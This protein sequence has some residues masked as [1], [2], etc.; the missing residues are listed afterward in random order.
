M[1]KQELDILK[2]EYVKWYNQKTKEFED[3]ITGNIK[4][5]KSKKKTSL[6]STRKK[7]KKKRKKK[8]EKN[9]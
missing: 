3:N 1:W 6:K 9:I 5:T 2:K 4:I 7:K 8:I